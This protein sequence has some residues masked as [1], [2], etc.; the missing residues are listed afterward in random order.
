MMRRTIIFCIICTREL[1]VCLMYAEPS[2][3]FPK[4]WPAQ[5]MDCY[6]SK[7]P[8]EVES[9]AGTFFRHEE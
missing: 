2:R 3:P 5:C 1:A 6:L 4:R 9:S 8:A 7:T